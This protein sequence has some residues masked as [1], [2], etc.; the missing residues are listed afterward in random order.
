MGSTLTSGP[1]DRL[2]VNSRSTVKKIWQTRPSL[3]SKMN[4]K[5]DQIKKTCL[6]LK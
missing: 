1:S 5:L 2:S 3:N 6:R 4:Q